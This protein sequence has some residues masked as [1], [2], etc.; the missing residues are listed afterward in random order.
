MHGRRH[1]LRPNL[2]AS[3]ADRQRLA[4]DAILLVY[5]ECRAADL[6]RIA[7]VISPAGAF[8]GWRA[9]NRVDSGHFGGVKSREAGN[10]GDLGPMAVL[11]GDHECYP[12]GYRRR[13][14]RPASR[15]D[16]SG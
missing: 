1:E 14:V 13:V 9:R 10:L 11:I 7:Q 16:A 3:N 15:A 6:R 2:S 5:H 4:P 12:P 8:A